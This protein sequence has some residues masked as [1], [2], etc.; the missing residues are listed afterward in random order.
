MTSAGHGYAIAVTREGEGRAGLLAA[1]LAIG[2][3]GALIAGFLTPIA[4]GLV[5]VGILLAASF[6]YPFPENPISGAPLPASLMIVVSAALAFL[7][8]GALSLDGRVFGR[9]EIVIPRASRPPE[10]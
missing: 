2:A 3:G 4:A 10:S 7:G 1:A 9:R 6:G 5:A 8:P